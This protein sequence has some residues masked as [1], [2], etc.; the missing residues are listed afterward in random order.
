MLQ[1]AFVFA[2]PAYVFAAIVLALSLAHGNAG[3]IPWRA[4]AALLCAPLL[5]MGVLLW[6]ESFTVV[7]LAALSIRP[8]PFAGSPPP[9]ER[10]SCWPAGSST[11]RDVRNRLVRNPASALSPCQRARREIVTARRAPASAY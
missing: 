9:G 6:I 4:V 2:G 8:W 7:I 11:S 10:S 3:R 1:R 5:L